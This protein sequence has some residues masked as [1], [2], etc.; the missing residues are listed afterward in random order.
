MTR[1]QNVGQQ[2]V[3]RWREG[4]WASHRADDRRAGTWHSGQPG[5]WSPAALPQCEAGGTCW[6]FTSI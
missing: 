3:R 1:P 2:A 4:P 5:P 6:A